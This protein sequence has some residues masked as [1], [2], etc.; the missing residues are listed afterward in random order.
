MS[1]QT[2]VFKREGLY[3]QVWGEPTRSVAQ[4]YGISDVGLA[5][6]C[7]KMGIPLPPRGFWAR[8]RSCQ[9]MRRPRLPELQ[10]GEAEEIII[11]VPEGASGL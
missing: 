11:R 4:K 6:I 10:S 2:V 5:K 7:R 8:V 9:R 3:E 1:P